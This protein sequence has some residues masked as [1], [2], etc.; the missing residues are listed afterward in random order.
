M[1]QISGCLD[2]LSEEGPILI[3]PT[4]TRCSEIRTELKRKL[5]ECV[6]NG[7]LRSVSLS[8]RLSTSE[9]FTTKK[10]VIYARERVSATNF[11][12]TKI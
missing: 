3:T 8:H 10:N 6:W 4:I 7:S 5:L 12:P 2:F 9:Y 1:S 11:L